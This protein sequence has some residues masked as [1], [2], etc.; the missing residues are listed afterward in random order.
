MSVT[1]NLASVV[2][3]GHMMAR[4][5]VE[6]ILG[7]FLAPAPQ[8]LHLH[9]SDRSAQN[10]FGAPGLPLVRGNRMFFSSLYSFLSFF[11]Y[12]LRYPQL[13]SQHGNPV[14]STWA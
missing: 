14:R 12:L 2:K 5:S 9:H 8:R 1:L 6:L 3:K 4:L 10:S 7:T 13:T 11:N